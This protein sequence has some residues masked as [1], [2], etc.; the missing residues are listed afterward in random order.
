MK[1]LWRS[2][3]PPWIWWAHVRGYH[4]SPWRILFHIVGTYTP[5]PRWCCPG[6]EW[7]E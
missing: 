1:L 4:I 2:Q 5:V 3:K 6:R 7:W